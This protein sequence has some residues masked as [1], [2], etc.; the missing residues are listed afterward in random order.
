MVVKT[1]HVQMLRAIGVMRTRQRLS[2][3]DICGHQK[4]RKNFNQEFTSQTWFAAHASSRSSRGGWTR[5]ERAAEMEPSLGP[6]NFPQSSTTELK[7]HAKITHNTFRSYPANNQ[8]NI[9][10]SNATPI[11]VYKMQTADCTQAVLDCR[12]FT[13]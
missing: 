4:H 10:L 12:S 2:S 3:D 8:K 13:D 5:H 9:L 11:G 7:F 6:P 1:A